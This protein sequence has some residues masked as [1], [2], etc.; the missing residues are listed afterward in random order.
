MARSKAASRIT[1]SLPL[2]ARNPRTPPQPGA[3]LESR[4][5]TPLGITQDALAKEL[6][7]SRRRVNELVRGRRAI[8]ADTAIRLGLYFRTGP[9]FWLNLQQAWDT[10]LAW[11]AWR[12]TSGKPVETK[13][14]GATS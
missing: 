3:F 1:P 5:L 7:V 2:H 6:G 10:H 8:S 12:Q 4:F 11:Q 14:P 9:D 13:F